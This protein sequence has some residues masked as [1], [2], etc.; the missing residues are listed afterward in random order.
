M[1]GSSLFWGDLCQKCVSYMRNFVYYDINTLKCCPE[2][3]YHD[4]ERP[5]VRAWFASSDGARV[6]SFNERIS[7]ARQEQL[8]AEGGLCIM[9][10]DPPR[11][12]RGGRH[13]PALSPAHGAASSAEWLVRPG[14]NRSRLSRTEERRSR[15]H[16]DRAPPPRATLDSGQGASRSVITHSPYVWSW[17]R[18]NRLKRKAHNDSLM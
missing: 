3:P 11:V 9:Y 4:P 8:E 6:P 10:K 14:L 17:S 18:S 2:M 16:L 15:N 13:K 5:F 1:P 7:E 12:C